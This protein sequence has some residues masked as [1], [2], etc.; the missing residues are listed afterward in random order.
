MFNVNKLSSVQLQF[1]T[2]NLL[3][4]VEYIT[5]ISAVFGMAY[6]IVGGFSGSALTFSSRDMGANVVVYC[7]A[8]S[9]FSPRQACVLKRET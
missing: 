9:R 8:F 1:N 6:V 3:S 4:N 7:T 2:F 5:N